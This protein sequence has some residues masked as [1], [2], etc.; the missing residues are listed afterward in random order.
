[1]V[2]KRLLTAPVGQFIAQ[3]RELGG[4]SE[5]VWQFILTVWHCQFILYTKVSV[6]GFARSGTG[7]GRSRNTGYNGYAGCDMVGLNIQMDYGH[8]VVIIDQSGLF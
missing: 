3:I 6:S 1:M 5:R 7:L 8:L 4:S 2:P